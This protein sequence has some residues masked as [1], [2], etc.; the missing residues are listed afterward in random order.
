MKKS[1]HSTAALA[2]AMT[3]TVSPGLRVV[4]DISAILPS[5]RPLPTFPAQRPPALRNCQA[6]ARQ[7]ISYCWTLKPDDAPGPAPS[8]LIK[9]LGR[10]A[11]P[12]AI[13]LSN[14]D[15]IVVQC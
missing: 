6:I 11:W 12:S 10:D 4:A 2:E 8:P 5:S 9:P 7:E 14:L 1:Y 13:K 15:T 3:A